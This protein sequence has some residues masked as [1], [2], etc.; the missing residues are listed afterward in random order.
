MS[1][2]QKKQKADQIRLDWFSSIVCDAEAKA[3][4]DFHEVLT[5]HAEGFLLSGLSWGEYMALNQASQ[6]AFIE[7]RQR[8]LVRQSAQIALMIAEPKKAIEILMGEEDIIR[9]VLEGKL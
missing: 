2:D 6:S 1:D 7:A 4:E 5:Q 9:K 8:I 3:P